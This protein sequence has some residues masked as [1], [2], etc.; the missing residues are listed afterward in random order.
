MGLGRPPAT[1]IHFAAHFY[2]PGWQPMENPQLY[3]EEAR[4][5]FRAESR[6]TVGGFLPIF[7]HLLDGDLTI[8]DARTARIGDDQD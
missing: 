8:L 1:T 2:K 7:S 3:L 4:Q 5:G 6:T